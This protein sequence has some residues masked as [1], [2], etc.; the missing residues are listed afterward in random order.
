MT[1]SYIILGLLY[2]DEGKGS[3]T[4]LLV[5]RIKELSP[6]AKPIVIRF[7]GGHQCGHTV[8]EDGQRHVFSTFGSGT[9]SGIPTFWSKYC[10]FN[11]I[12]VQNELEALL[13]LGKKPLLI[14]DP[15]S[16]LVTFMDVKANTSNPN[17]M[18]NGT[19]GVGFGSTIARNES[20]YK[21]F[22]QDLLLSKNLLM[23]KLRAIRYYY[24]SIGIE[25]TD[26]EFQM[27]ADTLLNNNILKSDYVK[28][29]TENI[30][31]SDFTHYVFEG[32][33]GIMLD[34]DFGF[35][36]HVTRSNTTSKNAIEIIERNN[37]GQYDICYVSR[38]YQTR[39][40][41]GP[42]TNEDLK[43]ELELNENPNETNV[44]N[45]W[46]G[47]FRKAPLDLE[48]MMY[49]ITADN[50]FSKEA[51]KKSLFLTCVDQICGLVPI[52][53]KETKILKRFTPKQLC[54]ELIQYL[55][56]DSVITKSAE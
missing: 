22:T 53:D 19:C 33:Q 54:Q 42:L 43:D 29:S 46:Q 16:P 44:T 34:M 1:N 35:F 55:S 3:I 26:E 20:P 6:E 41:N 25:F 13:K 48:I 9:L 37:L 50:N 11:P 24:N 5:K 31:K 23:T 45:P 39:H 47:E 27:N 15:M 4:N 38:V 56:L 49:A 7:N 21:L 8:V 12:G 36:P 52:T 17:Y 18:R 14:V 51:N 2:G 28:L 40:G 10:T 30:L 32:G